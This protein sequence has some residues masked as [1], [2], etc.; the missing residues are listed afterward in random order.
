[1][2]CR[3]VAGTL[4][5]GLVGGSTQKRSQAEESNSRRTHDT[6]GA[7]ACACMQVPK[8]DAFGEMHWRKVVPGREPLGF[9]GFSGAC[10]P[11][12]SGPRGKGESNE[13]SRSRP[14][15][16]GSKISYCFA[17]VLLL[18]PDAP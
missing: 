17:G 6:K 10:S 13:K 9:P 3:A 4:R 14:A 11:H 16:F 2:E 18:L 1:M 12:A 8:P 15:F 5:H 7:A